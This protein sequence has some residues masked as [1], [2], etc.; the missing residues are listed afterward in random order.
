[1]Y[2]LWTIT[3]QIHQGTLFVQ[4]TYCTIDFVQRIG[5]HRYS[6]SRY[7]WVHTGKH[8][9]MHTGENCIMHTGEHCIMHTEE[10]LKM[11]TDGRY[12]AAAHR[13]NSLGQV[14]PARRHTRGDQVP[15]VVCDEVGGDLGV[16]GG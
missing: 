9:V 15:D 13:P 6:F 10:H 11:H 14:R 1:M 12:S 4:W 5:T 3:I 7:T 2:L 8:C 16:G